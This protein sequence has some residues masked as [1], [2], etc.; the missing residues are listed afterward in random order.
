MGLV[1]LRHCPA[2]REESVSSAL[3]WWGQASSL[4]HPAVQPWSFPRLMAGHGGPLC[5]SHWLAPDFLKKGSLI[6]IVEPR[7]SLALRTPRL[8]A[9]GGGPLPS[10]M[11]PA[12][13]S[14]CPCV[15][16]G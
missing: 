13:A 9:H 5:P 3:W 6:W 16:A 2:C 10:R 1:G 14:P 11:N 15:A 4:H 12:V 7:D 8:L